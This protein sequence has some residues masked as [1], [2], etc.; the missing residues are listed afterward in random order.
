MH[1]HTITATL[2]R[3]PTVS[4]YA[5]ETVEWQGVS[6]KV[7]ING[8]ETKVTTGVTLCTVPAGARSSGFTQPTTLDG[9]IGVMLTGLAPGLWDIWATVGGYAP[10]TPVVQCGTISIT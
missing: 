4:S 5:R 2:E 3:D 6:V 7:K 8:V 10:E 1:R 9:D